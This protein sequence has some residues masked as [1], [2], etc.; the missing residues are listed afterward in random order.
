MVYEFAKE[1]NLSKNLLKNFF[2][3]GKVIS[4]SKCSK[5]S[6]NWEF[7]LSKKI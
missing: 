5:N 4:K 1:N 3:K 6:E 7:S 2:N